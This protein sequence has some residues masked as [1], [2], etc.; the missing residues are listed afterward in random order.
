M[1]TGM[2]HEEHRPRMKITIVY[3]N[4]A[5]GP[6]LGTGWG[7]SALI[8]TGHA[9]PLLF[10]T[11][12]DGD[13]L[14]FNMKALG[15]DPGR[16]GTIVISHAHGDHTGGLPDV[17][18]I[19]KHAEIYVPAYGL[20]GIRGGKVT[21]VGQ[22]LEISEG[23]FSTGVLEGIEQSLAVETARGIF[24]VAGCSHPGVGVILEAAARHGGV[25]G[26]IGGLHGFRDLSALE[27]LSLVCPCH[28]TLYKSELKRLFPERYVPCGA[29]LKMTL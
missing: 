15:I 8:E 21:P 12:A 24:V 19:N 11:G 5:C 18:E 22:P 25:C 23:V 20:P 14:L 16:I 26:I 7:F 10:D 28:C 29:G 9:P 1:T 3:D 27:G 4:E 17:L 13:T 2:S 6:G